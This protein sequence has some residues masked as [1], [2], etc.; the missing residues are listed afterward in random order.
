MGSSKNDA[1]LL[2]TLHQLKQSSIKLQGSPVEKKPEILQK[3]KND[4]LFYKEFEACLSELRGKNKNDRAKERTVDIIDKVSID[5]ITRKYNHDFGKYSQYPDEAKHSSNHIQKTVEKILLKPNIDKDQKVAMKEF[6]KS[7]D[8]IRNNIFKCD[9]CDGN[10]MTKR[11]L[12][13]HNLKYHDHFEKECCGRKYL[14]SNSYNIHVKKCHDLFQ[15]E[16]CEERLHSR[17]EK[18][19]HKI[20]VHHKKEKTTEY[21]CSFCGKTF[22]DRENHRRHIRQVHTDLRLFKCKH[23][24]R[25]FSDS[26]NLKRHIKVKHEGVRQQ[27]PQCS[28]TVVFGTLKRH[29]NTFHTKLTYQCQSCER[30]FKTKYGLSSHVN[31]KHKAVPTEYK[32]D[33]CGE[34]NLFSPQAR[35]KHKRAKHSKEVEEKKYINKRNE[36]NKIPHYECSYC[37]A[38]FP[39]RLERDRHQNVEHG[40]NSSNK[41]ICNCG[42]TTITE[43]RLLFHKENTC[44][45]LRLKQ[46]N[47]FSETVSPFLGTQQFKCR[48]CGNVLTTLVG[49][50]RHI[51]T[52]HEGVREECP[53]CHKTFSCIKK[54]IQICYLH[55]NI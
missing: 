19:K 28:Q 38:K 27:C 32:C 10:S 3:P 33:I 44:T 9:L 11:Q 51:K 13:M 29:I 4:T 20:T 35:V 1:N 6:C 30:D 39:K 24:E 26:G 52:V 45:L 17:A 41:W 5:E 46:K 8:E 49:L 40:D 47:T 31:T 34:G 14:Y 53:H 43:K 37:G 23:C 15:C 18:A 25:N 50:K 36:V 12:E 22:N 2:K 54:H 16:F 42:F 55:L 7:I 21:N 48:K